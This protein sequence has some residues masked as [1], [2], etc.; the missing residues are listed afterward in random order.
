MDDR[1]KVI[2]IRGRDCLVVETH[3]PGAFIDMW[4]K[5]Q[6]VMKQDPHYIPV[7]VLDPIEPR[8]Y[9]PVMERKSLLQRIKEW[10]LGSNPS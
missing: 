1:V 8:A 6:E 10:F 7:F 4:R 2:E 5:Q 9:M 3:K